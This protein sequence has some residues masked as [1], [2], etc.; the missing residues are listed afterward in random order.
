MGVSRQEHWSGLP[1]PP[2]GDLS[3]PGIEPVSLWQ[4]DS[5]PLSRWRSPAC[6]DIPLLPDLQGGKVPPLQD[7][8]ELRA[9]ICDHAHHT[10]QFIV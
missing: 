10:L 6:P 1:F 5:L 7:S 9:V 3:D 8:L 4:A 2:L